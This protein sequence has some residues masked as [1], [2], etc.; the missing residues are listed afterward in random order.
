[1]NKS[2]SSTITRRLIVSF[3]LLCLVLLFFGV[4]VIYEI[5][6]MSSLT[7][8]I[9]NHPLVVSNAALQSH[10]SITKMHR[11]MKDVVLF[12][13]PERIDSAIRLVDVEE[14]E[15]YKHL[16]IVKANILGDEGRDLETRARIVFANWKEIRDEV[17]SLV[18]SNQREKAAEITIGKGALHVVKL[19][20]EMTGLLQYARTKATSFIT[21]SEKSRT[22]LLVTS[23]TFLVTATLFSL[24][25]AYSTVK[26]AASAESELSE[27]RQLL[28]NAIDHAPIGMVLVQPNGAFYR[29]NQA[30]C[31]I[32]GYSEKELMA[33]D[34]QDITHPDDHDIGP[35]VIKKLLDGKIDKAQ[36]EKRYIRK[37]GRIID[38]VMNTTLLKSEDGSP[39]YFFTQAQD[40]TKRKALAQNLE[41]SLRDKETLLKEIHHRVKNNM[42]MIQSILNLQIE[43]TELAEN[44]EPLLESINRIRV[45]SLVHENLYR[46]SNLADINLKEYFSDFLGQ[47]SNAFNLVEKKIELQQDIAHLPLSID[48]IITCGLIVNELVTNAIKYGFEQRVEGTISVDLKEVGNNIELKVS[49]DGGGFKEEIDVNNSDTLGL[50]IV[51]ILAE[52]QL[53]GIISVVNNNGVTFTILFPFHAE[54][55]G[56]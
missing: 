39:L 55:E 10:V 9:Y 26:Y 21:A 11:N 16:D 41:D 56:A 35:D 48:T 49:D 24:G 29:V 40:I 8:T 30:Y 43:K 17:I 23:I 53:D 22:R 36:L 42:Q 54:L 44:K 1:M 7:R 14:Q 12:D 45:M 6:T 3:S 13:N 33:K 27:S 46:S 5:I 4:F 25:V 32:T 2:I 38:V 51:Q 47:L 50:R 52:G 28:A 31:T 19:E 34:F 37:D 15:V 20:D 18:R